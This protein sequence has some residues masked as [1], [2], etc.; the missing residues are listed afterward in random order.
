MSFKALEGNLANTQQS[1]WK[2]SG[3]AFA[4]P[5]EGSD[6]PT[7]IQGI[8]LY[9]VLNMDPRLPK[10]VQLSL[11]YTSPDF[12]VD[13]NLNTSADMFSLGL[14]S[15]APYN[16][17]HRSPLECHGSLSTYK[18]LFS[19]SSSVPSATNNYL[20]SRPSPRELSHDVLPRPITRPPYH[21]IRSA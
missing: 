1:D 20:S 11:D 10:V 8:N 17:P 3:L 2:I 6:K 13:N 14:M 7:S 16:F 12:V 21:T 9:E 4:S 5:P 19:S 18:R 15:V